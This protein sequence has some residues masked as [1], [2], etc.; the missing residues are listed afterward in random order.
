MIIIIDK[1]NAN[2]SVVPGSAKRKREK[3]NGLRVKISMAGLIEIQ[4][5]M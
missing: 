5:N 3:P 1:E 2:G 4:K